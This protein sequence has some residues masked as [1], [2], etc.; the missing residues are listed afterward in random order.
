MKKVFSLFCLFITSSLLAQITNFNCDFEAPCDTLRPTLTGSWEIGQ[1]TTAPFFNETYS[2]DGA[3][4]TGAKTTPQKNSQGYYQIDIP[5]LFTNINISFYHRRHFAQSK[6]GG[7]LTF[8]FDSGATWIN[9]AYLNE[10]YTG[11]IYYSSNLYDSTNQTNNIPC[12][13]GTN[14]DWT[15]T[16]IFLGN[17][18][19]VLKRNDGNQKEYYPWGNERL[20]MRFNYFIGPELTH[21][22][23]WCIDRLEITGSFVGGISDNNAAEKIQIWP[24]PVGDE[25]NLKLIA[26]GQVG[27]LLITDVFGKAVLREPA[28]LSEKINTNTLTPGTYFITLTDSGKNYRKKFIKL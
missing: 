4:V 1:P 15:N 12:F 21:V 20:L 10:Y 14:L 16:N 25:L 3:L 2:G 13:N 26:A 5:S 27:P 23:G 17:Y 8:S 6:S 9:A 24:N 19:P 28:I 11:E 22:A 18:I 7:Y